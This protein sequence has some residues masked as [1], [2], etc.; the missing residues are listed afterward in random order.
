MMRGNG[1]QWGF[2]SSCISL[3][4]LASGA[5]TDILFHK[6]LHFRPP[7]V[8]RNGKKSAD[9]PR[10]T[11]CWCIMVLRHYLPPQ[12][13]VVHYDQATLMPPMMVLRQQGKPRGELLDLVSKSVL[14]QQ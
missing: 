3:V 11:R 14:R 7:V 10:V 13:V 4:C 8:L 2:C 1:E 5:S 12:I 6:V 9:Y